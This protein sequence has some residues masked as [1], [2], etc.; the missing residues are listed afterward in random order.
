MLGR[1]GFFED[2]GLRVG[3]Q[4]A[5]VVGDQG[6]RWD[7]DGFRLNGLEIDVGGD[8]VF[9]RGGIDAEGRLEGNVS[10]VFDA[11]LLRIF[12]PEWEP[13]GRATGTIEILGQVDAPRLEGIAKVERGSFRLPGTRSVVGDVDGSLFLS[14]GEVALEDLRFKFMRGRGRGRGELP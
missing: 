3:D 5:A 9:L 13:A 1:E 2:S 4:R 12:L 10:G 7:A 14:A 8:Q 6:F 11:R